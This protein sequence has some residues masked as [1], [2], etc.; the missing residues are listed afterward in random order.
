MIKKILKKLKNLSLFGHNVAAPTN[1]IIE[2]ITKN[3][4]KIAEIITDPNFLSLGSPVLEAAI[5]IAKQAQ[6][7]NITSKLENFHKQLSFLPTSCSNY[8]LSALL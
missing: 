4:S 6:A 2:F 5:L 8:E 3:K 1:P 7:T